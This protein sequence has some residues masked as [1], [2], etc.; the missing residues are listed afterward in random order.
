MCASPWRASQAKM[1]DSARVLRVGL[2]G[3][4]KAIP[5]LTGSHSLVKEARACKETA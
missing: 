5:G 4:Y 2:L 1:D 3:A